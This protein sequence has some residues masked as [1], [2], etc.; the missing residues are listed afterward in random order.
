[1]RP[2]LSGLGLLL[3]G[4]VIG[5]MAVDGLRETEIAA[6]VKVTR[7]TTSGQDW[8]PAASPDGQTV[9]FISSRDGR[10]RVWLRQMKGGTEAPLTDGPDLEP[11]FSPDGSSVLFLRDEGSVHSA[12][13]APVVGGPARKILD[14]VW[15]A[16][17]SPEGERLAFLRI[18]GE[19]ASPLVQVGISHIQSGEITELA[20][21]EGRF[22]Y[23]LRWS[24]D[25]RW[26]STSTRTGVMN[27]PDNSLLLVDA[28]TGELHHG[29][30]IPTRLSSAAWTA[31]SRSLIVAYSASLVGDMA[32][33]LGRVI[34]VDPFSNR[35]QPLF[36]VRS[37]FA[38]SSDF[39]RFEWLNDDSL[40]FD[41]IL[42]R[43]SLDQVG[44]DGEVYESAGRRLTQGTGRDR[45]PAFSPDGE[46][47]VF[48]SDRSGNLDIWTIEPESGELRQLTDDDADDWDP[49]FSV[50]GQR[51]LWSSN[52]SGNLEIWTARADGSGARQLTHDGQ[53]AENPTQTADGEW[54]VYASANPDRNG[55]WKIRSD[56]SEEVQV[57]SGA[58]FLPEVSPDGRHVMY[59]VNDVQRNASRLLV[60][61]LET[62][63]Q[64]F[65]TEIAFQGFRTVIQPGR[66]RWMPDGKSFVFVGP[67][68]QGRRSLIEQD[69]HPGEDTT[70]SRRILVTYGSGNDLESFG[71][72][73]DGRSMV[74]ARIAHVRSLK[75]AEG[76]GGNR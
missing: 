56:G 70:D 44:A 5:A 34:L 4:A 49:A 13:R 36:W 30:T 10:S 42:W 60:S 11:R 65:T 62:H 54:I 37:V 68:E 75:L 73:P 39:A 19:A 74:I 61:D 33:S 23:G 45:Q 47:I 55:V 31:D 51:I 35:E 6:P 14:N 64:V 7:L 66:V 21:I 52:R 28:E 3:L 46:S 38:G 8:S 22:V 12:Y 27:A 25:G 15:D 24:P 50:D 32:S 71:I 63:E 48:S 18:S 67:A 41:E 2:F 69:F 29:A 59:L 1:M 16:C 53:D 72:S 40:V 26:L 17:W 43:G 58:Y 9:A 20:V 57:A 76:V